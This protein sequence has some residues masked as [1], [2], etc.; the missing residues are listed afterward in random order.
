[1][2]ASSADEL[3]MIFALLGV[4]SERLTGEL[5]PGLSILWTNRT[6]NALGVPI[7]KPTGTVS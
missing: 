6:R 5:E 4:G 2:P 3:K 7:K 1:M